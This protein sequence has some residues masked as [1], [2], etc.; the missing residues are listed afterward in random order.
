MGDVRF[1]LI[2]SAQAPLG[3]KIRFARFLAAA[4]P[5]HSR[6]CAPYF[7]RTLQTASAATA[8]TRRRAEPRGR[9]KRAWSC[10]RASTLLSEATSAGDHRARGNILASSPISGT[11]PHRTPIRPMT[12]GQSLV[13][14][15]R[16]FAGYGG[17]KPR[18]VEPNGCQTRCGFRKLRAR[19]HPACAEG[20]ITTA[21]I[22]TV[23]SGQRMDARRDASARRTEPSPE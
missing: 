8:S 11:G 2:G 19:L 1:D 23:S 18:H 13:G 12:M 20:E 16:N 22:K 15:R 21:S 4:T 9:H 10:S 14:H 7:G 5:P 17:L 3:T 6:C